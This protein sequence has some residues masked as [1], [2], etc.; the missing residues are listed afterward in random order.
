MHS[1]APKGFDWDSSHAMP[2]EL[3]PA[4]RGPEHCRTKELLPVAQRLL[5]GSGFLW[6]PRYPAGREEQ[7][8]IIVRDAEERGRDSRH[9]I[10]RS[11]VLHKSRR[12]G[13]PGL[14]EAGLTWRV[15][16]HVARRRLAEQP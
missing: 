9:R 2:R 8:L 10:G 15:L 14:R 7:G 12:Q 16:S 5:G 4:R 13:H 11:Y 1:V 3:L 6:P